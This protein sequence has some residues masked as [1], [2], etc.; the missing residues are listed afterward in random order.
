MKKALLRAMNDKLVA[1]GQAVALVSGFSPF[2]YLL[3]VTF[4]LHP[5]V[6][7]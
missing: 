7:S 2:G 6:R 1:T 3:A 4:A 5:R